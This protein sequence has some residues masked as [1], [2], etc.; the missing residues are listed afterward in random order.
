MHEWPRQQDSERTWLSQISLLSLVKD[1]RNI[2]ALIVIPLSL[3]TAVLETESW[4]KSVN[5]NNCWASTQ[6][7]QPKK[8]KK[9]WY[10][11][12]F[13]N[14]HSVTSVIT[15]FRRDHAS[16]QDFL[17]AVSSEEAIQS[18]GLNVFTK[19]SGCCSYFDSANAGISKAHITVNLPRAWVTF[20]ALNKIWS[21]Y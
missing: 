19:K 5:V 18:K 6:V 2:S 16:P 4:I 12:L 14:P 10:M 3:Q 15:P 7:F 11:Q 8:K 13:H 21:Q 17:S 20:H 9:K 1:L